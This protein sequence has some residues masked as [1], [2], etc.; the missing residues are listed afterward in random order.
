MSYTHIYM[1]SGNYS[2]Q[3]FIPDFRFLSLDLDRD[4]E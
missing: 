2:F 3:Q 4:L 1:D